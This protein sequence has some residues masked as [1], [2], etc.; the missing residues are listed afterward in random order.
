MSKYWSKTVK[1]LKPYIPGEQPTKDEDG[2]FLTAGM[3]SYFIFDLSSPLQG[4]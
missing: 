1:E 2:N 3:M 4:N